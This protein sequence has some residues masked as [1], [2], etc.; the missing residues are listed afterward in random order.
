MSSELLSLSHAPT[1]GHSKAHLLRLDALQILLTALPRSVVDDHV[2]AD[3]RI[4]LRLVNA[5]NDADAHPPPV[6]ETCVG[7]LGC[8]GCPARYQMAPWP[9]PSSC[10]TPAGSRVLVPIDGREG[11]V[12]A[13]L[14]IEP[15]SGRSGA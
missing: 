6:H 5:L 10:P 9:R 8:E 2:P 4:V 15:V 11:H 3:E 13:S 7:T 1:V 12:L 14:A